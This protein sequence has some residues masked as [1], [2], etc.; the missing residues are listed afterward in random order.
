VGILVISWV[1]RSLR[2]TGRDGHQ[3]GKV[4]VLSN[5]GSWNVV[6]LGTHILM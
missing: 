5:D 3:R 1:G 6:R 2:H 4:K